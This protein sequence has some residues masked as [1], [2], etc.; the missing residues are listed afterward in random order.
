M[1]IEIQL[2]PY[3][4]LDPDKQYLLVKTYEVVTGQPTAGTKHN[5][6]C[7]RLSYKLRDY[8]ATHNLGRVSS[9]AG[10]QIDRNERLPDLV[11]FS[12][13]RIPLEGQPKTQWPIPDLA[14]EVISPY[15]FYEDVYTNAMEYL[16]AG[17]KQ[18]WL[19]SPENQT[20]TVF[21]SPTN[22]IAFPP[23]SELV[24]EDLFPGFRC[25][26]GEIFKIPQQAKQQG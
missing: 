23:E 19:V 1:K 26:L 20:I 6:V 2:E 3:T 17:V 12:A 25:P 13:A 8:L 15:D 9:K 7:G 5:D 22:I 21:R 10:V 24:I 4:Q 18:V 14:V 11:F 16:A